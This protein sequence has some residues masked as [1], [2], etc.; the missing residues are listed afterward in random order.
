M[1]FR[2]LLVCVVAS[3]SWVFTATAEQLTI[4]YSFDR[5]ELSKVTLAGQTYDRITIPGCPNGGNVGDPALPAR[6]ARILLP[7]GAE[8]LSVEIVSDEEVPLGK[9]YFIEPVPRPVRLSAGPGAASPPVPNSAIYASDQPFPGVQFEEIGAHSFRGYA[10]VILKLQ[11]VDPA[12]P[13]RVG[14]SVSIAGRDEYHRV[15]GVEEEFVD[16]DR[17][18]AVGVFGLAKGE[19]FPDILG[20]PLGDPL[21]TNASDK[22]LEYT[23]IINQILATLSECFIITL[24]VSHP[25]KCFLV[26]CHRIELLLIRH[27]SKVDILPEL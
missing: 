22:P 21:E 27:K 16:L 8:V 26:N 10:I 5:P 15:A 20:Y 2:T 1:K 23:K 18:V 13:R 24:L 7:A 4:D 19:K 25:R 3:G 11:P 6:G 9:G 14:V 12:A 17:L